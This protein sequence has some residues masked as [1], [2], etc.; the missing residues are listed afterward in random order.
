MFSGD[1]MFSMGLCAVSPQRLTSC[2]P[3]TGRSCVWSWGWGGWEGFSF[4]S[5]MFYWW[6]C[7]VATKCAFHNLWFLQFSNQ[8]WIFSEWRVFFFNETWVRRGELAMLAGVDRSCSSL[9]RTGV[10]WRPNIVNNA[11]WQYFIFEDNHMTCHVHIIV[12][13]YIHIQWLQLT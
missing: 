6:F 10:G 8:I 1:I 2:R 13:I 12:Y 3:T 5:K 4:I 9:L 7:S 11:Q